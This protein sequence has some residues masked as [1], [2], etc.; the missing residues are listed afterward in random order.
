MKGA[1]ACYVCT[2]GGGG[3]ATV[4]LSLPLLR[5]SSSCDLILFQGWRVPDVSR[6][7]VPFA[8]VALGWR[9]RSC[10]PIDLCRAR[11]HARSPFNGQ[12]AKDGRHISPLFP[13]RGFPPSCNSSFH[14]SLPPSFSN[15][16]QPVC[17]GLAAVFH[18]PAGRFEKHSWN[19]PPRRD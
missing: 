14:T 9:G 7:T 17:S 4:S 10:F 11:D 16:L 1:C 2:E 18:S 15:F 13:C 6:Q 19:G 8:L 12:F 3:M 5:D